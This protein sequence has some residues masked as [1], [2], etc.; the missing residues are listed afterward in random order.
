MIL[1]TC[2]LMTVLDWTLMPYEKEAAQVNAV[3]LTWQNFQ[4][5]LNQLFTRWHKRCRIFF[6]EF[7]R[8]RSSRTIKLDVSLNCR[9]TC[10]VFASF[11]VGNIST[12]KKPKRRSANSTGMG[13]T[14]GSCRSDGRDLGAPEHADAL[15]AFAMG[16]VVCACGKVHRIIWCALR[17]A[18]QQCPKISAEAFMHSYLLP[19]VHESANTKFI[20][21]SW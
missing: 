1:M 14:I 10:T 19:L 18:P 9:G 4:F 6:S 21:G 12:E 2:N 3:R 5:P 7:M 15:K 8:L 17:S 11:V 20:S 13:T 16:T